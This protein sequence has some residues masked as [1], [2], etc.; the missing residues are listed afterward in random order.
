MA[1]ITLKK[2][3]KVIGIP[4]EQMLEQMKKAG[5]SHSSI[6]QV[7]KDEDKKTLLDFLKG[8]QGKSSVTLSLK[9]KNEPRESKVTKTV[10]IRRKKIPKETDTELKKPEDPERIDFSEIEK[11][12]L[13]GEAF[14]KS[15]DKRR[16][17]QSESK[18]LV[19]R[20]VRKPTVPPIVKRTKTGQKAPLED[21]KKQ[22]VKEKSSLSKREQDVAQLLLAGFTNKYISY[23]L[24]ISQKTV[25]TFKMRIFKKMNVKSLIDLARY[26]NV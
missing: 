19:K 15:E 13:Q 3:A 1:N 26:L 21:R 11:K 12:R 2:L 24:G 9:K 17:E 5:L 6:S 23:E 16:K 7:V 22:A 18:T 8:E 10:S 25:S 4:A 20:K 14:K